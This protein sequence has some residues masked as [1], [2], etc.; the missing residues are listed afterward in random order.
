MIRPKSLKPIER[1]TLWDQA[2]V[3]LKAALL[4]GRYG[5]GARIILRDVADE[6]E[7]SLNQ[8]LDIS[9]NV[10]Q[11][12]SGIRQGGVPTVNATLNINI[13]DEIKDLYEFE[14]LYRENE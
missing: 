7:I 6:L 1:R 3:T 8:N 11:F 12:N 14:I 4:E 10:V 5:P 9:V 13:P 2:Y